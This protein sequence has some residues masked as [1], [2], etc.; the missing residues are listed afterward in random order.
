MADGADGKLV[1]VHAMDEYGLAGFEPERMTYVN[2]EPAFG[3]VFSTTA[4]VAAR[5]M[6]GQQ[7]LIG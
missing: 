4:D 3:F 7:P 5:S 2:A 6:K 1:F